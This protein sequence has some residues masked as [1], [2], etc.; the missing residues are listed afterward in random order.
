MTLVEWKN[1]LYVIHKPSVVL[2]EPTTGV[3]SFKK[4]IL[5]M[6]SVATKGITIF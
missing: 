2:D 6:L 3:D 5:E 4:R 1:S